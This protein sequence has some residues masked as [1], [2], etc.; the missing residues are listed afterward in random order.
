VALDIR[1]PKIQIVG[2]QNSGKTTVV[3]NIVSKLTMAGTKIGT[4]KHHG[5]GGQPDASDI[6]KDSYRHRQAGAEVTAVEGDGALQLHITKSVWQL[7][8]I[9]DLYSHFELDLILIEGFKTAPYKKVVVIREEEHM[10]LLNT[11]ENIEAI[12][13]WIPLPKKLTSCYKVFSIHEDVYVEWI[14]RFVRD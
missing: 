7:E 3:E 12:V 13:T 4:I 8:D 11:L 1:I 6:G 10:T 9:I 14:K 5:H 2:F